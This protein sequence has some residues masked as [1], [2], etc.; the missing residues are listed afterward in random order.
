ME[1][2]VRATV[3]YFAL[4]I[5]VRGLGKRELG[6]ISPLDLVLLVVIGDMVQQGVTQEDMSLSGALLAVA[7][8]AAW[9]IGFTLVA[10]RFR[11]ASYVIEGRPVVVLR[12]GVPLEAVLRLER[13][14]VDELKSAAR[15]HGVADLRD[16]DLAILE[17]DG[18]ISLLGPGVHPPARKEHR[19]E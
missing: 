12:D 11:R 7:T 17:P 4:W 1:I 13:L 15:E 9:S 3:V 8:M 18:Q 5:L 6:E 10:N 16:L 14:T 19:A 2:V